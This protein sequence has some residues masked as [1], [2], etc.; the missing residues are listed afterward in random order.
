MEGLGLDHGD[1]RIGRDLATLPI[2]YP[3]NVAVAAVEPSKCVDT[4]TVHARVASRVVEEENMYERHTGI[5]NVLARGPPTYLSDSGDDCP[6]TC[7]WTF[8]SMA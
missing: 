1:F 2:S 6:L 8:C 7:W 4:A 3:A 5:H